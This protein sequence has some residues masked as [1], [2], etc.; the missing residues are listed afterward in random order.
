MLPI[1]STPALGQELRV[2]YSR[3]TVACRYAVNFVNLNFYSYLERRGYC[4]IGTFPFYKILRECTT[5]KF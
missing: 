5:S 3:A 2:D 1:E 4:H